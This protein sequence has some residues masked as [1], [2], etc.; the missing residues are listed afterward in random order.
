MPEMADIKVG[1]MIPDSWKK[2]IF[3]TYSEGIPRQI[4]YRVGD[5]TYSWNIVPITESEYINLY[6]I[7]IT[8]QKN[9]ENKLRESDRMNKMLL[10][11]LPYPAMLINKDRT[12]LTANR[13]AIESGAK[14]GGLCWR[15]FGHSKFIDNKGTNENQDTLPE[16][17]QC[18]F[19]CADQAIEG[20][21]VLISEVHAWDKIWDTHWIA[22][23]N[24]K[25]LRYSIDITDSKIREK[26]LKDSIIEKEVLMREI[27]HRVKN[28]L[29]VILNFLDMHKRSVEDRSVSEVL[30]VCKDRINVMALIHAQ[31]YKSADISTVNIKALAEELLKG[32]VTHYT[33][34]TTKLEYSVDIEDRILPIN[35]STPVGLILNELIVNSLKHA[36][37]G[38]DTGKIEVSLKVRKSGDTVLTVCDDGIGMPEGFDISKSKSL[39]YKLIKILSEIQ[40]QGSYEI[41]T[42]R[43]GTTVIVRFFQGVYN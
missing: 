28:N 21:P 33:V 13:I 43:N 26:K 9:G 27:Q 25:Y 1:D 18:W 5:Y 24:D 39:G 16:I 42:G 31:L 3:D 41:K 40:L 4:E 17:T 34:G 36:F 20:Q 8:E 32:L 30:T 15:D 12:I 22:L 6:A 7:D 35:Y 14:I 10:N 11:T 38:R 2:H 23:D 37:F 19:C 29:N